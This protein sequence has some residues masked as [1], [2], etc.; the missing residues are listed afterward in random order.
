VFG[1]DVPCDV[2]RHVG[3]EQALPLPYKE[4]RRVSRAHRI[5]HVKARGVF[6]RHARE[7]ALAARALDPRPDT[8]KFLFESLPDFLG[9][10]K[11]PRCTR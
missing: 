6:L 1:R 8:W 5:G 4:L 2:F 9:E 3:G 11:M 7:D 10:L